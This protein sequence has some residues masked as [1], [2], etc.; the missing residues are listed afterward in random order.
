MP[1]EIDH[2]CGVCIPINLPLTYRCCS[3]N[4]SGDETK[5]LERA[6]SM[7][8][9]VLIPSLSCAVSASQFGP[10]QAVSNPSPLHRSV[11]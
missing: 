1:F 9:V 7:K 2:I 10:L 5:E 4:S 11:L 8:T 3:W 6:V